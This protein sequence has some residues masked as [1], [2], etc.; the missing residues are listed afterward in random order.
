[1]SIRSLKTA[2]E[3][4]SF[5]RET[6]SK[7]LAN[8]IFSASPGHLIHEMDYFLRQYLAHEI[9][10]ETTYYWIQRSG[11]MPEAMVETYAHHFRKYNLEM[12]ADN[13]MFAMA[14]EVCRMVPEF[15][16][17]VGLGHIRNSVMSREN[18]YVQ[19]FHYRLHYYVSNDTVVQTNRHYYQTRTRSG[20]ADPWTDAR[21]AIDGPLADM[22]GAD[23]LDRIAAIHLR[24]HSGNAGVALPPDRLLPT[25]GF[26]RDSGYRL[27]K[28]GTEL[29]PPEFAG[30]GIVNYSESPLRNFKNDLA[31]L[32]NAKVTLVNTSGLENVADVMNLPCV[33][34]GNWPLSAVPYSKNMVV[35][36][37]L[38]SDPVRNRVL[39]FPEQ[40]LA[41]RSK[42]EQW[43][44]G[45]FVWHV[46]FEHFDPV[47]PRADEL[48]AAT[49]EAI[50][51]GQENRPLTDLQARFK[52]LDSS[53]LTAVS[54][55][56]I[57]DYFLQRF[58]N[59][60]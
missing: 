59:L 49:Q 41:Y 60:I 42:P 24:T 16:I 48:L 2:E 26:L 28:V 29:T 12:I 36:P 14:N 52:Q 31:V 55:A 27:V 56:R 15:G 58:A 35:V 8:M 7:L 54:Q 47:P 19:I 32:T 44:T 53:G 22:I 30:L 25:L 38:L 11:A 6:K 34:Y 40:M 46:P 9:D 57:S 17:N 51:L 10:R 4:Y 43:E 20:D 18:T 50:Q 33:S 45:R 1:M 39:T 21:P 3:L 5:L 13:D 37:T 23:G